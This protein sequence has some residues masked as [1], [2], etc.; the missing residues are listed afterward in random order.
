MLKSIV[1]AAA[2]FTA[3]SAKADAPTS[4]LTG[5]AARHLIDLLEDA[6]V[7]H[8]Q[9]IEGR[10]WFAPA[11]SCNRGS[12]GGPDIFTSCSVTLAEGEESQDTDAATADALVALFVAEDLPFTQF[13]EGRGWSFANVVCSTQFFS[14]EL[15]INCSLSSN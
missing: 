13:I 7:V 10:T 1:I 4:T 3:A 8:E 6:G 14:G 15:S 9:Q 12:I 5:D 11:L 2:L